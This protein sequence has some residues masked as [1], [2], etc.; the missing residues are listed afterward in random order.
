MPSSGERSTS[1]VRERSR[2]RETERERAENEKGEIERK[3][4][5]GVLGCRLVV[6]G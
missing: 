5:I 6:R 3:R 1:I 2:E 4:L